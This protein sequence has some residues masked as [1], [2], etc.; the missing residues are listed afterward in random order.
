MITALMLLLRQPAVGTVV[1][2]VV[3]LLI[4]L[5]QKIVSKSSAPH[6]QILHKALVRR[7]GFEPTHRDALTILVPQM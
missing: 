1:L 5:A 7:I 6:R 2:I 3:Q 4:P